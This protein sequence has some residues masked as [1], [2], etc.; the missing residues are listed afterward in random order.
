M[1]TTPIVTTKHV[2]REASHMGAKQEPDNRFSRISAILI[3][4]CTSP[5]CFLFRGDSGRAL[6]AWV[7]TIALVVSIRIFWGRRRLLWFWVTVVILAALHVLLVLCVPW[8][9]VHTTI[10]GPAL[11]PFGLLDIGIICGC[12]KLIEK[13]MESS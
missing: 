6:A 1:F 11:G 8:P 7:F 4:L 3:P 13:A 12:F 5:V 9:G 10:G 2:W